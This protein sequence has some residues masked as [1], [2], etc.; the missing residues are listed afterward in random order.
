MKFYIPE[1][2]DE[3]K[4]TKDWEFKVTREFRNKELEEKYLPEKSKKLDPIGSRHDNYGEI[5][6]NVILPKGTVL[7]IDRIYIRK[8]ASDYSSV[9]FIIRSEGKGKKIRFFAKLQDCNNIEF[10]SKKKKDSIQLRESPKSHYNECSMSIPGVWLPQHLIGNALIDHPITT[11]EAYDNEKKVLAKLKA[12]CSVVCDTER[13]DYTEIEKRDGKFA[14][15]WEPSY[16]IGRYSNGNVYVPKSVGYGYDTVKYKDL[17]FKKVLSRSYTIY[18]GN[19]KLLEVK[20]P[21]TLTTKLK[22][23]LKSKLTSMGYTV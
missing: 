17:K 5:I 14:S 22:E 6:G 7:S 10:E 20:S 13:L 23:L 15:H 9:T 12:T 21:S 3:I 19:K 2:G 8:G 18:D 4:L 1:I 16:H 11:M